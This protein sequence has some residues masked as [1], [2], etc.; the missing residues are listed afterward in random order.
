MS[1]A[2]GAHHASARDPPARADAASG[3]SIASRARCS[4][5]SASR[6]CSRSCSGIAFRNRGPEPVVVAVEAPAERRSRAP[7]M[8]TAILAAAK[9]VEAKRMSPPD[10]DVALRTGKV[11]LV[12]VPT[13]E[14]LRV[15]LRPDAPGE[16]PRARR[17]RRSP[18]ARGGAGPTRSRAEASHRDRAGLALHR[19]PRP[20]AHRLRADVDRALGHRLLARRD[21]HEEAPQAADRDADAAR[22][23]PLLVPDRA[24]RAAARGARRRS[25]VFA[26][27]VFDVHI[28]GSIVSLALIALVGGLTF[29][30]MGLSLASRARE[31]AG[32][33]RAHQRGLV[34][35]V[36]VLGR[37]LLVRALP[38]RDAAVHRARCRSRR[39]TTRCAR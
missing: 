9:D 8:R 19:L 4:G 35:D 3:C 30:G 10:A 5:R 20:R 12:V 39:S 23:L 6:S 24:R 33:E 15:S 32:G 29:A 26:R 13:A 11:S 18:A 17:H 38:G 14:R 21:A 1:D 37:L 28:Q 27:F 2:A 36:P 34:P 7:S 16:P 25:C 22:R 31:P